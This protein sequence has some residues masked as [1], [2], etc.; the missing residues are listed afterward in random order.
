MQK[1]RERESE[2]SAETE[3][4]GG[5][6]GARYKFAADLRSG[7]A[8]ALPLHGDLCIIEKG[9]GT[10][11]T[12]ENLI[13]PLRCRV[14]LTAAL[15]GL[16]QLMGMII[17]VSNQKGGVGKTTTVNALT[18]GLSGLGLRVLSVDF[19]PQGNLSFSLNAVCRNDSAATVYHVIK[20]ECRIADAIQHREA[21]DVLPAN[22]LLSALDVEFTGAGRE[23]LLKQA[24]A[25]VLSQYDVI[26]V[27]TP[28][29]LGLLTINAFTAADAI[30]IPV[31]CDIYSLQGL[32]QLNDTLRQVRLRSNPNIQV[33]GVLLNRYSE[34]EKVSAV[35]RETAASITQ[36]LDMPLLDTLIHTGVALTRAQIQQENMMITERRS[37]AVGDY[38]RLA[39]ELIRRGVV[40]VNG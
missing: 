38:R 22:L 27:D 1:K 34:R 12:S 6:R 35:V 10:D 13:V 24:L 19:D 40:R 33:A 5:T 14:V 2:K 8:F 26:L 16:Y 17:C 11:G 9:T 32:I 36:S 31:L 18:M 3:R 20:K 29:D 37:R 25:P 30:L 23:Y 39:D 15:G 4:S 28:P 7:G 21:C